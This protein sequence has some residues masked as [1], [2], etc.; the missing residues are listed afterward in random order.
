MPARTSASRTDSARAVDNA[1]LY[2][3]VPRTSVCPSRRID[4]AVERRDERRELTEPLLIVRVDRAVLGTEVHVERD[5]AL[6]VV[7]VRVA[8]ALDLRFARVSRASYAGA[9]ARSHSTSAERGGLRLRRAGLLLGLDAGNALVMKSVAEP[10]AHRGADDQADRAARERADRGAAAKADRLLFF[11]MGLR[12]V[13][14]VAGPPVCASSAPTART[15]I[16]FLMVR[17][18]KRGVGTRSHS[19]EPR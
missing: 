7:A 1:S 18:S 14:L 5:G 16:S 9:A 19:S 12:V 17:S 4:G 3:C 13:A 15:M 10:A 11:G 6:D 2:F 8:F